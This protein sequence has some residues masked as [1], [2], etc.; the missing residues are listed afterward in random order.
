MPYVSFLN[1][2]DMYLNYQRPK[3]YIDV[4]AA[5]IASGQKTYELLQRFLSKNLN[6]YLDFEPYRGQWELRKL[7]LE[8]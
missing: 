3:G 6:V 4:F 7:I 8:K 5:S 1:S 2:S